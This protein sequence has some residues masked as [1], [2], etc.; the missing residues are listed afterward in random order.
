MQRIAIIDVGSN[1]AR[2]VI[3]HIYKNGAYNMVYNQKEALRLSQKVDINGMLTEEA[4]T[5][6]LECMHSFATMCKIFDVDK[7]VAVATAAMRNAKNG[8]E[9]TALVEKETD[10]HLH[11]LGGKAE[12]YASYLGV[13]NTINV[14]DGIIF[15][16]GGGSTELVLFHDRKIVDSVSLP[17]GCVNLTTMFNTRDRMPSTVF[18][19]VSYLIMSRLEKYPWLKDSSLPLIGVGGTARTIAKIEQ[20]KNKYPASKIHNFQFTSQAFRTTFKF[21]RET[22]L[23]Q[24]RKISG[25]GTDRADLILAGASVIQCLLEAT[26][27]KKIIVS[28]CGIREGLFLD[29]YAKKE[30]TP[31]I[32]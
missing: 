16:L 14:K 12:A 30:K 9:L 23:E 18:S 22:S 4:F 32:A 11:I 13:I 27:G 24:R 29:Y 19:D 15:D 3:T 26:G 6:T 21:L 8:K 17:L 2:L 25:L 10:I 31:V 1:S 28:G 5:C 7:I 20:K